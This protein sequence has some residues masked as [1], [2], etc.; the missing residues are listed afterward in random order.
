M[1]DQHSGPI[2]GVLQVWLA[3]G[4]QDEHPLLKPEVNIGRSSDNDFVLDSPL[5][6][7][8]HLRLVV[9][10]D[11]SV[12]AMDL[13]SLNGTLLNGRPMSARSP[14]A[15]QAEDILQVGEFRFG[16][17]QPSSRAPAPPA[18]AER[19]RIS[20]TPQPALAVF[21]ERRLTK[22]ALTKSE[23][24]LGR[25]HENDVVIPSPEASGYHARLQQSG[26]TWT[27][28]DVGSTN[29]LIYNGQRVQQQ[30]LRDGDIVYIGEGVALQLRAHLGFVPAV[31]AQDLPSAVRTIKMD[32]RDTLTVG[33]APDNDIV[34]DHPQVSRYHV[35]IERLGTRRRLRDLKSHNGV[36]VNKKR[37]EGES[38]LQEGDEIHVGPVRLR[39]A[40]EGVQQMVE[41]G[42]QLDAVRLRKWVTKTKNLLQGISLSIHPREF[43]ALVGLSGAGKTTLMD[44][45]NGFRPATHGRVLV[46]GTNLYRNPELFRSDVGYVPQES[47]VHNDLTVYRALDYA[48][49]LRMPPDTTADERHR[50]ILEVLRELDLVER[51]DLVIAKLSG[52]QRKRVSIGVELLTKPRLFF[53]DE[54]T[55]GLDPGTEHNM[56]RLLRKLADQG[57]TIVLVTHATKNVMMCDKVLIM[58][59]GGTVAFYGPPEEALVYFDQYRTAHERRIKDIE[60]DDTYPILEDEKRGT[61]KDWHTRYRKSPAH[62]KYI[63]GPLE[64][65]HPQGAKPGT[66]KGSLARRPR[67]STLRQ[68]LILARRYMELVFRDRVLL[69][70]LLAVMPMIALLILATASPNQLTGNTEAEVAQQ[71][72]AELASGKKVASYGLVFETQMALSMMAMAAVLLGVYSAAYELV[73]ERSIYRRERLAVLR[74]FPY[75]ASKVAVLITFALAQCLLF[76]FVISLKVKMPEQGVILPATVEIYVTLI[77]AA[78]AAVMLGLLISA[79]V[80]NPSTV[81]YIV[82]LVFFVQM[83]LSGVNF[84]LP[85]PAGKLS[86][87]T[88][89]RWANEALG[90][91]VDLDR[92]NGLSRT[93]FQGDPITQD[94][95]MDI[96]CPG[97]AGTT[98]AQTLTQTLTIEPEPLEMPGGGEFNL[99]YERTSQHLVTCWLALLG[100][101]MVFGLGTVGVLRRRDKG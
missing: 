78:L 40:A 87:L 71:L 14:V 27:I 67:V 86:V 45:L 42:V 94:V 89:S 20:A 46:N 52:G 53:L 24:K 36:F 34:I 5:V 48:A 22:H 55:S 74:L 37:I 19:V 35:L 3:G 73:K 99:S 59:R 11:H 38:W 79:I 76:I 58:A 43:V 30:A 33:R 60:F 41:E 81:I 88:M 92:L 25:G 15:L 8:H 54:P 82:L 51:K 49:Q 64:K 47:I 93:V 63:A 72:A 28:Q 65:L 32:G 1:S 80:P 95:S 9:A 6:S 12:T 70:V 18:L 56:M 4:G 26:D 7:A 2:H 85:G 77:L 66:D 96:Q 10:A 44:A 83:I 16:V 75:V 61:P 84:Q 39:L 50:R 29:G 68:F 57:R 62:Q 23:A 97:Q 91:T 31:A 98:A 69:T 21:V 100:L 13:G 101:G 90:A 17:R